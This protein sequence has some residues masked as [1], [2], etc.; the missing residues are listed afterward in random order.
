[1]V[2]TASVVFK[3]FKENCCLVA[4]NPAEIIKR[5]VDWSKDNEEFLN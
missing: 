2:E 3:S 5:N 1:M 4:G